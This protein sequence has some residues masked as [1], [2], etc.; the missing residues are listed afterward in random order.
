MFEI[1]LLPRVNVLVATRFVEVAVP[2]TVRFWK[3]PLKKLTT[4]PKN[5]KECPFRFIVLFAV[6]V[7]LLSYTFGKVTKQFS[8]PGLHAG[9]R[10]VPGAYPPA[11]A[12]A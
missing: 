9:F 3:I 8:S 4:P 10:V 5:E 2:V 7:P 12:A 1:V 11:G 6:V